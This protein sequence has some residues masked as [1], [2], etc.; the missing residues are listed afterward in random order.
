M[1]RI[2]LCAAAAA[3]ALCFGGLGESSTPTLRFAVFAHVGKH[4]NG[5]VWTGSRFLYAENT[6]NTI[7]SAPA[8]GVPLRRVA[9]MP[10]ESEEARCVLSP[11]DHGFPAGAV[12]C[13]APNHTVYE[14]RN[15]TLR[16]FAKLPVPATPSDDGA[17]AFDTVGKFGFRLVAATG[18]SGNPTP[19]GGTVFSIDGHGRVR[20]VG[21]YRGPGGADEVAIAPA[22]FGSFA[23][24][25]LLTVDPGNRPG[26]VVAMSPGGRTRTIARVPGPNPILT[27]RRGG[28]FYVTDDSAKVLYRASAAPLAAYAGDVL[29]GSEPTGAFWVLAPKDG[30]VTTRAIGST[31]TGKTRSLEAMIQV[32]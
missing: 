2:A 20:T 10:R 26:G 15:G 31:L 3:V 4:L 9:S 17:L 19:A 14:L 8:A 27:I 22:G 23:G 18:R 13:H 21:G 32:P 5:I 12:Y 6:A 7:W 29:V 16:V 28:S 25:A 24:D 11:G 1:K 30:S